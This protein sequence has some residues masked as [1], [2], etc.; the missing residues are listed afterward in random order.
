MAP[1][2]HPGADRKVGRVRLA[3]RI[4]GF[5]VQDDRF[6]IRHVVSGKERYVLNKGLVTGRQATQINVLQ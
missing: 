6:T 4:A 3:A 5:I 1:M 2:D